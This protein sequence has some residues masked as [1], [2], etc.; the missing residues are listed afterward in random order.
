M[1]QEE[2]NE[3]ER[4]AY[5]ILE[6]TLHKAR[7]Q[8]AID[9]AKFKVGDYIRSVTGIIVKA[10]SNGDINSVFSGEVIEQAKST[11]SVGYIS[12]SWLSCNFVEIE[13][14]YI[15]NELFPIY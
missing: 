3:I 8:Y 9:N 6:Y 15:T 13:D 11:Y 1:T 4:L 10:T 7:T 14:K 5:E 12:F 2:L